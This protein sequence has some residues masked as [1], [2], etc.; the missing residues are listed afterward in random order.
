MAK[1]ILIIEDEKILLNLLQKKISQQGYEVVVAMDGEMG[2]K[3]MREMSPDLI[4]LDI[5]MPKIDGFGVLEAMSK[6]EVLNKIPVI[7]ISN[8]GQPVELNRAQKLGLRDWLIKTEFDP[9]EV[10]EKVI[11]A[12][13]K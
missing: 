13:G 1:Q 8:S 2:L 4:L 6:N 12:I 5:M 7:I 10:I 9:Q 3:K 11:K